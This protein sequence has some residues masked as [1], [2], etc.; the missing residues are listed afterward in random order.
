MWNLNWLFWCRCSLPNGS[1]ITEGEFIT[2]KEEH[3]TPAVDLVF[4]VESRSCNLGVVKK[5]LFSALVAETV[6]EFKDLSVMEHRYSVVTFGGEEKPRSI[7][8]DGHVFTD[9][10]NIQLY[11]NHLK[12]ANGSSVDV[13]TALTI[14]S[15]LVFKPGASKI[16]VLSLCSRC[17]FNSLKVP[18]MLRF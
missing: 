16:F 4:V 8:L 5:K 7:T 6:K 11:F 10:K 1:F 2:L 18:M 14:A 17:E 12:D 9:E 15:K 13:F 3:L